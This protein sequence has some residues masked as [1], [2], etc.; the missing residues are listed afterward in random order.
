MLNNARILIVEDERVNQMVISKLVELAGAI[1]D[2][3]SNGAE[4]VEA[5]QHK[6]YDLVL[7]DCHMPVVDGFEATRLLRELKGAPTSA[8]VPI[9]ALTADTK[10]ADAERCWQA[11]MDGHLAKPVD[12]QQLTQ[13]IERWV[14]V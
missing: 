1:S 12:R 3:A 6:A 4:A 9:V 7:M 5:A 10:F 11:G 8:R 14:S 13:T 2:I